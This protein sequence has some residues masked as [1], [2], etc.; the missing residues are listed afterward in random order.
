[1]LSQIYQELIGSVE[2]ADQWAVNAYVNAIQTDPADPL[3]RIQLGNILLQQEQLQQAANLFSQAIELKPD[4]AASYFYLGQ[5]QQMAQDPIGAKT[6]WQQALALLEVD[7]EDYTMLQ[8]LLEELEPLVEQ[9]EA[10]LAAQQEGGAQQFVDEDGMPISGEDMPQGTSPLGQQLPS[11]TDQN[12]E[13][14][15]DIVSQPGSAPLELADEDRSLLQQEEEGQF[16]L[17]DEAA[18]EEPEE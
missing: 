16:E 12:I 7:S 1:M 10:Q 13:S 15:D 8:G 14:R 18:A 9:A 17:E 3:L 6:S 5:V 4:L 11:L 2:E